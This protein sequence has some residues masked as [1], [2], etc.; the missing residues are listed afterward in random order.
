MF[1]P[2]VQALV[3]IGVGFA[4]LLL[5]GLPGHP[6]VRDSDPRVPTS[7]LCYALGVLLSLIHI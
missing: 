4:A 2:R 5:P 7:A 3:H 1:P 6:L